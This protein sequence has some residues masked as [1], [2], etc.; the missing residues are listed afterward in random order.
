M[1]KAKALL[2][3]LMTEIERHE[4]EVLSVSFL[5]R[6]VGLS[7]WQLQRTFSA[8]TGLNLRDYLKE[9]RL[10]FAADCLINERNGVLDIALASGFSSQAAF[11]RAF[12]L[13][14]TLTPIQYRQRAIKD[15]FSF[16]LF[17]PAEREW[18]KAMTIKIEKKSAMVLEGRQAYFNG[19]D[20][21]QANNFEVIPPLWESL[22]QDEVFQQ[23]PNLVGYGYICESDDRAQGE[24]SYLASINQGDGVLQVAGDTINIAEQVYA[25]VPHHGLLDDLSNTLGAFYGQWLLESDYKMSDDFSIEIYDERFD[26]ESEDSY[27]EIWVPVQ[28]ATKA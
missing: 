5:S 11:S 8:L 6:Q 22:L 16:N 21:K 1:E 23:K 15:D 9:F 20:S 7:R 14:F 17:I 27:F 26:P 12:K 2:N 10:C 4:V 24:L 25:I 19:Y 18:S 13:R 3:L 28:E